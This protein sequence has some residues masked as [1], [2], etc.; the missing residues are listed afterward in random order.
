MIKQLMIF[1]AYVLVHVSAQLREWLLYFP[2]RF[3]MVFLP[4]SLFNYYCYLVAGVLW[5]MLF[6]RLKYLV[7]MTVFVNF[8][9]TFPL[10][11]VCLPFYNII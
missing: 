10:Y 7:L 9:P 1:I 2:C 8:T 4:S 6:L 5:P 3:Y 11:M